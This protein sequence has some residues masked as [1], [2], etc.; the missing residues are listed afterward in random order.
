MLIN[1]NLSEKELESL[2]LYRKQ[3]NRTHGTSYT[4]LEG[5]LNDLTKKY[6]RSLINQVRL[7]RREKV[8]K[9]YRF[10]NKQKQDEVDTL[11]GVTDDDG[12]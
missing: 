2:E 12:D 5:A 6:L 9:A 8:S 11:L 1:V 7:K 3:I 4:D 10:A